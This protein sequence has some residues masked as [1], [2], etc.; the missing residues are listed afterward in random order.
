MDTCFVTFAKKIDT[1]INIFFCK[2]MDEKSKYMGHA[3]NVD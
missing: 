1:S 2:R 3:Q